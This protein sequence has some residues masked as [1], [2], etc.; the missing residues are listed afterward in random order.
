[1]EE[2]KKVHAAVVLGRRGGRVKSKAKAAAARMNGLL[3]GAS[4]WKQWHQGRKKKPKPAKL[5]TTEVTKRKRKI[6]LVAEVTV[7]EPE[8]KIV[9]ERPPI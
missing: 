6:K 3:G 7:P 9:M 4:K 1:M 5:K 2:K 8:R